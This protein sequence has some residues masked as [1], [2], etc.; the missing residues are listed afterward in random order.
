MTPLLPD[1]EEIRKKKSLVLVMALLL[2]P[3]LL[4]FY[5]LGTVWGQVVATPTP[6]VIVRVTASPT[7]TSPPTLTPSPTQTPTVTPSPSSTLTPTPIPSPTATATPTPV[8][9]V[10]IVAPEDGGE[11]NERPPIEGTASPRATVQ[12]YV[13]DEL[14]GTTTSDETGYWTVTPEESLAEGEQTITANMLDEHEQVVASD[15]VTVTVVGGLLPVTG[16][17]TPD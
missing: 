8:P 6:E 4:G 5:A 12:V 11:V 3:V 15:S 7:C 2:I 17:T 10:I 16:G 14:V 9:E 1:E 13:G